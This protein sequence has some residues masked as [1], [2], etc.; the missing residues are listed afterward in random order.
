MFDGIE[1]DMLSLGDA[2]CILVTKWDSK[3]PVRILIDGGTSDSAKTVREFLRS[4]GCT[5][6]YA[7][8]CTHPHNDHAA[9]LI[10]LLK[11]KTI[12]VSTGWMH[13]IRKHVSADSLR[14]ASAGNSSQAEGVKQVVETTKELASAFASQGITTPKEPFAGEVISYCAG[15]TVLGPAPAFYSKVLGEFTKVNVPALAPLPEFL[16]ARA[17]LGGE[18]RPAIAP[19]Y[20]LPL[21]SPSSDLSG[22]LAGVLSN[23]SVKEDPATQPFNNTSAILGTVYVGQKL[24]FTA[25]AG[26]DALDLVPADWK[27]LEWMQVPHHGSDGNLSQ[28][29]IERF[30]P[31]F[32][33]VSACG[34][35][36]HPSRAIVN[37]LIKVGSQVFSTHSLDPGHLWLWRGNVPDRPGM[38]YGPAVPLKATGQTKPALD[39][40]LIPE[41]LK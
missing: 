14:R 13:D 41:Y 6:L 4:I 23:S 12:S 27:S 17:I 9:G 5:Y 7:I 40:S 38:G 32:A 26:S 2:D 24:L 21:P 8:V 10:E 39:L 18:R 35:T 20:P 33:Y 34:D 30:S 25:D 37:G 36:S 19:M 1:I 29:N 28:G 3:G 15:L 16:A 22:L 11:D 31:R